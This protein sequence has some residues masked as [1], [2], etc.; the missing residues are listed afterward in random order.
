M[1]HGKPW[2]SKGLACRSVAVVQWPVVHWPTPADYLHLLR[3]TPPFVSLP[4]GGI[5]P[6]FFCC[7][8]LRAC[9]RYRFL[10]LSVKQEHYSLVVLWVG[11]HGCTVNQKSDSSTVGIALSHREQDWL[12]RGLRLTPR[13]M[14]QKAVVAIGPKVRVEGV[15]A[16]FRGSLHNHFPPA[17]KR[18]LKQSG[19]N[20]FQL[21]T[22]KMIEKNLGHLFRFKNLSLVVIFDQAIQEPHAPT[23]APALVDVG[24]T[25]VKAS[26]SNIQVRPWHLVINETFDELRRCDC[27]SPSAA[28]SVFH[29]GEF[30]IDHLVVFGRKG[31]PPNQLAGF[32]ARFVQPVDELI[33]VA[34]HSGLLLP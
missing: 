34:E 31:H 16:L 6:F 32:D 28:P 11:W 18:P 7:R 23:R 33:V 24:L 22:L 8:P 29:I 25:R 26:S 20:A 1:A 21:L 27:S 4:I 10:I 19:K 14:G 9:R 17:F 5:E 2:S 3:P 12:K 15:D 30:G 13:T